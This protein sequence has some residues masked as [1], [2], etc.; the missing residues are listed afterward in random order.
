MSAVEQILAKSRVTLTVDGVPF[1][2]RRITA[3]VAIKVLG[4]K[5]FGLVR[6]AMTDAK[7]EATEEEKLKL[8]H[9][10]LTECMVSPRVG[11]SSDPEAD[12]ISLDDL[13]NMAFDL[14]NEL[15]AAS[16]W[17]EQVGDFPAP[18]EE[19]TE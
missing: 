3:P 13:G 6:G 16:D 19:P 4:S 2:V 7:R 14:F 9:L 11:E 10:Y 8:I 1:E 15:M 18:S 12:T 5:A 17:K